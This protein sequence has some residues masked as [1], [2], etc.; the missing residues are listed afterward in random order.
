M[1]NFVEH[2]IE[3]YDAGDIAKASALALREDMRAARRWEQRSIKETYA[4]LL[5][6]LH[7]SCI[8]A[9]VEIVFNKEVVEI[10]H[11]AGG[12]EAR[13]KDG[14]S[15]AA[16]KAVVTVPLPLYERIIFVPAL[17]DRQQA[18]KD[19]GFGPVVKILMRFK[20]KWWAGMREK[21]FE[22]LFFMFSEE[23]IPTWWTQYPAAHTTLTGWIA[24]PKALAL[25][26]KTEAEIVDLALQSLANIFAIT[27]Q[28]LQSELMAAKAVNW[29]R[30]L[31]AR[32]AYS[33]TTPQS[34]KAIELLRTPVGG[35]LYF[36]GEALNRE[37]L[38]GTVDAA[39]QTGLEVAR[40]MLP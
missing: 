7:K 17:P 1:R 12:I 38:V 27:R 6:H 5:A 10:R 18:A 22:R 23:A 20:T 31:Y 29:A 33:Y 9:G 32:G 24:G 37:D 3:G 2:W 14:T 4:V 40:E 19:I 11:A 21:K 26:D 13:S 8:E 30:D 16:A 36:A 35:T 28:E 25:K 15:Y 39:L 34:G